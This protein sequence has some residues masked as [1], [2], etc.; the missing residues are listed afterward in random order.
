[1]LGKIKPNMLYGFRT[2]KTL[3]DQ[4]VWYKLNKYMGKDFV[5]I[6]ILVLIGS[7]IIFI[8]R[9]NLSIEIISLVGTLL[10]LMPFPL[11]ILRVFNYLKKF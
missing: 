9:Y 7:L 3:S 10:V 11:I 2:K 6:G 5:F 8:L 1:M 4:E